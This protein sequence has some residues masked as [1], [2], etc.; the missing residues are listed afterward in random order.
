L[1]VVTWPTDQ[2]V[3]VVLQGTALLQ[4]FACEFK[5]TQYCANDRVA[6]EAPDNSQETNAAIALAPPTAC[7]VALPAPPL[8]QTLAVAVALPPRADVDPPRH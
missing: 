1:G 5:R 7:A 3:V 2:F 6:V 4:I 8:A